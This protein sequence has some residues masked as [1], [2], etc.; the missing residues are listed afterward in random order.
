M[1]RREHAGEK[2]SSIPANDLKN[3]FDRATGLFQSRYGFVVAVARKHAPLSHYVDDIVQQAFIAFVQGVL[4]ERWDLDRDI[5]PL[6]YQITKR[7]AQ[8][9]WSE[10]KKTKSIPVHAVAERIAEIAETSEKYESAAFERTKL[11]LDALNHC[12]GQLS[13]RNRALIELHYYEDVP[14]R[15]IARHQEKNEAAIYQL[16]SRLRVKL[17]ECIRRTMQES[18]ENDDL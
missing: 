14:V 13:P 18:D 1:D 7:K 5:D 4:E 2:C 8:K 6:L 9:I 15:E 10:Q 11:E 12:L 16:F 3:H 17:R